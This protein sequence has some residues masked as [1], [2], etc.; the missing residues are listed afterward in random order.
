MLGA[1]ICPLATL[2][3]PKNAVRWLV[4]WWRLNRVAIFAQLPDAHFLFYHVPYLCWFLFFQLCHRKDLDLTK[5]GYPDSSTHSCGDRP[6]LLNC[7]HPDLASHPSVAPTSEAGFPS[8][9]GDGPQTLLRNSDQAFRTEFNLMYAYSPLNAMP[10][11]DGLYRGSPLVG[12][13]KPLHLD[14]GYCSPA[15]GFSS[16]YEHGFMK[17]LSR[18]SMSP[19][20]ERTCEGVPSAPQNPP[21]R[22]KVSIHVILLKNISQIIQNFLSPSA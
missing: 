17:D 18:G 11:A 2:R 19:G 1:Q 15:E 6:S 5:V 10:R 13:R 22:K 4:A 7:S 21:Q 14:G 20:G 8:R 16:R 3:A 12:D 9:S